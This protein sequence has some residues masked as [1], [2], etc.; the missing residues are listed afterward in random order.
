MKTFLVAT[1]FSANARHAAEY[2][3][4]LAKQIKANII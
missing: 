3:Y 2:G 1:D 4:N